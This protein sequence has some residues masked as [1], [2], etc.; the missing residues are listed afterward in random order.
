MFEYFLHD[1]KY[2]IIYDLIEIDVILDPLCTLKYHSRNNYEQDCIT[3]KASA[4]SRSLCDIV[5][6]SGMFSLENLCIESEKAVW[7]LYCDLLCICNDGNLFDACL[8]SIVAALKTLKIP[9]TC[10]GKN[11]DTV[12][13][14]NRKENDF[15]KLTLKYDLLP[16]TFGILDKRI[17][18][19]PT[20]D[21]EGLLSDVIHIVLNNDG[22]IIHL[23]KSG[24]KNI[25]L[26]KL[27]TMIDIAQSRSIDLI[28]I[29]KKN[30][31]IKKQNIM[32]IDFRTEL[33]KENNMG[34]I[35]EESKTDKEEQSEDDDMNMTNDNQ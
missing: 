33:P 5:V 2:F 24:E 25:G 4:L 19:D 17:I 15:Y 34:Y 16:L 31:V 21:E 7:V 8:L 13:I 30:C 10:L 23:Y 18:V 9:H 1:I 29:L 28:A 27:Q 6:S 11:D 32:A 35:Q 12:Y 14:D 3:H 22:D 20:I 26:E